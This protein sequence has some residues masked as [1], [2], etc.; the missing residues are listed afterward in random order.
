M[1]SLCTLATATDAFGMFGDS[2]LRRVAH[3]RTGWMAPQKHSHL[4]RFMG[5]LLLGTAVMWTDPALSQS[6][7]DR[8]TAIEAYREVL[9]RPTDEGA[10]KRFKAL[11]PRFG[12]DYVVEGDRILTEDQLLVYLAQLATGSQAAV[13]SAGELLVNKT[14][15]RPDQ[16]CQAARD[17]T[18]AV[19]RASFA[20]SEQYQSVVK[21]IAAAARDWEGACPECKIT[22]T[23][24][25]EHDDSPKHD[26]VVFIVR[27]VD[28]AGSF[29]AAAFFPGDAPSR[30]FLYV[31][32]SYFRTSFDKVG[33][34]RHELGH[35][36]GYRHEHIQDVPGC[37]LED[38]NWV[39]LGPY[40]AHST[41]H[42]LCGGGGSEDFALQTGD[43][44]Q[45]RLWYTK[46][47]GEPCSVGGA[48]R[49][50]QP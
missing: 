20:D 31:D 11:F 26:K 14:N 46:N 49:K 43:K 28:A 5:I 9:T 33:V 30:R 1:R 37:Y 29:I 8:A 3:C 25:A 32:S 41:M 35:V 19:D 36:L 34:F 21:N 15:G 22:F 50:V 39:A 13:P 2:F 17:L 40:Q 7:A 18:Y 12:E 4:P 10:L 42:Y 45:H 6:P 23:H 48:T 47:G 44:T 27:A 38:K 16:W 24:I